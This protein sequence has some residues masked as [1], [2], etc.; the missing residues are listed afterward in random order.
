MCENAAP[1][2]KTFGELKGDDRRDAIDRA[3]EEFQASK[4]T[5]F[6]FHQVGMGYARVSCFYKAGAPHAT[7]RFLPEEIP[8]FAV[9]QILT[10]CAVALPASRHR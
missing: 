10:A 1:T 5:S 6:S 7:F 2:G 8:S 9:L 3:W 4:Q